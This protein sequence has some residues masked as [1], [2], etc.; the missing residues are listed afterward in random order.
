MCLATCFRTPSKELGSDKGVDILSVCLTEECIA[1]GL[2]G[3]VFYAIFAGA[4]IIIVGFLG[5]EIQKRIPRVYSFSDYVQ[6]V[7]YPF[8]VQQRHFTYSSVLN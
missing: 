3:M 8:F 6:R 4:P 2:M 7:S 1:A 5:V